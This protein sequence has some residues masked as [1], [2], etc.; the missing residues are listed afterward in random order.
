MEW[1]DTI[2]NQAMNAIGQSNITALVIILATVLLNEMAIPIPFIVDSALFLT[3]YQSGIIS[4]QV[5]IIFLI[6]FLGRQC[7]SGLLYWISRRPGNAFLNWLGRRFPTVGQRLSKIETS[8]GKNAILVITIA[9]LTGLLW[10]PSVAAGVLHLRYYYLALGIAISSLILD[11]LL[12]LL[13]SGIGTFLPNL[14][15]WTIIAGLIVLLIIVWGAFVWI[16]R[17]HR[18]QASEPKQYI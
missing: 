18:P 7:G 6:V 4:T 14:R 3:S 11:G 15:P 5:G 8:L 16:R 2:L 10:I 13:G 12:L 9:R 17:R 1:I